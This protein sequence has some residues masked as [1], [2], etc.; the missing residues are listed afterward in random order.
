M[1]DMT[2]QLRG[3]EVGANGGDSCCDSTCC[4]GT[5]PGSCC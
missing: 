2:A 3:H 1:S 4:G 5:R